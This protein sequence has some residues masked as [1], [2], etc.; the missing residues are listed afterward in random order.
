MRYSMKLTAVLLCGV[1]ALPIWAD[2]AAK[3][4]ISNE[5]NNTI[6]S[7]YPGLAAGAL[8]YAQLAELAEGILLQS[9][10]L[11]FTLEDLQQ[12][13]SQAPKDLQNEL[14]KNAFLSWN[15]TSLPSCS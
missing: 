9:D 13:I 14:T 4:E 12:A 11:R 2:E 5:K 15:R 7:V 10:N 1:F 6:D 3:Q 8:T